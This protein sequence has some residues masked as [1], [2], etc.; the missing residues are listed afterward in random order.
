MQRAREGTTASQ[1]IFV[2]EF[3]QVELRGFGPLTPY[4]QGIQHRLWSGAERCHSPQ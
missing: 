2:E 1:M 3:S 4:G